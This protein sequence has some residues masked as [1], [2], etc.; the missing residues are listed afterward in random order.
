MTEDGAVALTRSSVLLG[1]AATL[2]LG[3]GLV[4]AAAA[5]AH[6]GHSQLVV[7]FALT[8][9]A[10][11]AVGTTIAVWPAKPAL[12]I[13]VL[14]NLAVAGA[15]ALSRLTGMSVL[16]DLR[17]PQ[18]IG[19]QDRTATIMAVGAA[20][21]A[22]LALTRPVLTVSRRLSPVWALA[23]LPA[24]V[25]MTAPHSHPEGPHHIEAGG[26][27]A[28]DPVF[29]GLDTSHAEEA[30]LAAA[31]ALILSTR[32]SVFRAFPDE[33][34]VI[35]AGYR[36]IGDGR[37]PGTY[38]HFVNAEYLTDGREVDPARIESIVLENTGAGK[39]V[40]SAMYILEVG[41][42]MSEVPRLAGDL[43]VWHDHQNLCW[44]DSGIR[45]AGLLVDG[46][47]VPRGTFRP[48]P[49]MLHVWLQDHRC[50][51]FAGIDGHGEACTGHHSD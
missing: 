35:G 14:V 4:H 26:S 36:S 17:E 5:A 28:A 27:L 18:P 31:K 25:G 51:P 19:V 40:V 30:E 39:R 7:L 46:Q 38:E 32:E 50:G 13:A 45:L 47:C 33:A 24:L 41:K 34:S 42:T 12:L 15:W 23:L 8:A 48:T 3:A 1:V 43:T 2:T 16:E 37:F 44:D 20:G 11:V 29:S 10:Q 49:P 9:V 22:L 6:E 21:A